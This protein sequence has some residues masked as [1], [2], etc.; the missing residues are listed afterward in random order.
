MGGRDSLG[1]W[2]QHIPTD[3]FKMDKQQGPTVQHRELSSCSVA[4]WWERG[5]RENG[6]IYV[7]G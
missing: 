2:D 7:C 3:V 5:L 1:V 4:A 6:Y